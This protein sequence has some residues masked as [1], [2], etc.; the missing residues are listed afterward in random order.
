ME[1]GLG[2]PLFLADWEKALFL[3]F[4]VDAK[5]LQE[6]VPFELDLWK[7]DTAILSLV[8]FTMRGMR[9]AIGGE[10]TRWL[11]GGLATH[12]FLNARTYVRGPDGERGIYFICEWLPNLLARCL[13]PL[14]YG[15]PY[16]LGKIDYRHRHEDEDWSGDVVARGGDGRLSYWAR[17]SS[18]ADDSERRDFLLERYTAFTATGGLRRKFRVWHEPW[19]A[20]A[21]S[22]ELVDESILELVP[23]CCGARLV[24]AHYAKGVKDVWMGRPRMAE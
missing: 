11:F 24:A 13:G 4:E 3:H 8:A 21:M 19:E 9:P 17:M 20:V 5:A 1:E 15:L 18:A 14:T 6:V 16:R 23:G 2:D 7:G 12:E 10:A 22:V